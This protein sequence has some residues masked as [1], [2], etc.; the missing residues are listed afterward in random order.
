VEWLRSGTRYQVHLDVSVGPAFA[1]LMSRSASSE[2]LI[3]AEGLRPARFDE[4]T[5][6]VWRGSRELQLRMDED[7]VTLAGG[8]TVPRPEGLQ[9]TASQFVQLTWLFNTQ[10]WL[11]QPGQVLSL[12][13]ALP[14]RV[15]RWRYEV[16]EPEWLETP[17]GWLWASPV[18]PAPDVAGEAGR[19]GYLVPEAWFAPTLQHL[20]VRILIR[21]PGGGHVDLRLEQL[22]QQAAQG[23]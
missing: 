20:P 6:I 21:Q 19:L 12:P 5:R 9:D 13:L 16:G 1:P 15:L 10:P 3:T 23:R 22:P 7:S 18:R 14:R 17:A 8:R 2:G 4:R 11:L